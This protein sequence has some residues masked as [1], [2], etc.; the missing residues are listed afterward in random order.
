MKHDMSAM[1]VESMKES[2]VVVTDGS[3]SD[4]IIL[5]EAWPV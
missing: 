4:L 5:D 3:M 2:I 1:V